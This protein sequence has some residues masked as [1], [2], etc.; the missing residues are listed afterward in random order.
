MLLA[1]ALLGLLE[2]LEARQRG[3]LGRQRGE[4]VAADV[5]RRE[6]VGQALEP[7]QRE[8]LVAAQVQRA[9]DAVRAHAARQLAR[10][11]VA[12]PEL[13]QKEAPPTSATNEAWTAQ[14]QDGSP[15]A[16]QDCK[17]AHE[18]ACITQVYVGGYP[19]VTLC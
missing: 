10:V 15:G 11:A 18:G 3:Q 14:K 1:G 8:Q 6:A 12:Q 17:K 5:E 19:T 7:G 9:H 16:S 13:V 4:K 2:A